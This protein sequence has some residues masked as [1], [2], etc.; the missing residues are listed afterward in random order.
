[1]TLSFQSNS[2]RRDAAVSRTRKPRLTLDL[3]SLSLADSTR[4]AYRNP[5][6]PNRSSASHRE[7]QPLSAEFADLLDVRYAADADEER[8]NAAE[9]GHE[10]G[11]NGASFQ[12][13]GR[14]SL[15]AWQR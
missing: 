11:V 9:Q 4:S 7:I 6:P 15:A 5:E 2:V 1:M 8:R 14:S 10:A 12:G 3:L 13:G